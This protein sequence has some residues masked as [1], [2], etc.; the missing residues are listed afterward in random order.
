MDQLGNSK[1][2]SGRGRPAGVEPLEP[3]AYL[4]VSLAF[5]QLVVSGT[6]GDDAILVNAAPPK[7]K[8]TIQ[9][10]INGKRFNFHRK[11]VTDISVSGLGGNDTIQIID[12]KKLLRVPITANGGE[13]NDTVTGSSG[14]ELLKG[15]NGDDVIRGG[16]GHDQLYG[17]GGSDSLFGEGGNDTLGGDN[18]DSLWLRGFA[19]P[20]FGTGDDALDGGDGNDWLLGGYNSSTLSGQDNGRET[21]T[22]GSGSD[23]MDARGGDDTLV[24]RGAK[25]IVPTENV[26]SG[27]ATK[28]VAY[29]FMLHVYVGIGMHSYEL[30]VPAGVGR[31]GS[32]PAVYSDNKRRNMIHLRANA[33]RKFKLAEV[34]R[35][36]GVSLGRWNV[37][38]YIATAKLPFTMTVNGKRNAL[39]GDYVIQNG[40]IVELHFNHDENEDGSGGHHSH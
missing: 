34:F 25:D 21:L 26:V 11:A 24:D 14:T 32:S 37:G 23:V 40:D 13:G 39:K 8:A 31:F 29:T 30:N 27:K 38:P 3:R 18:N 7:T 22:G 28:P 10:Q 5:G 20:D 17:G 4:A 19:A 6:A 9:V 1:A 36:L 2:L 12:K 16:G 15:G 33:P 35:N